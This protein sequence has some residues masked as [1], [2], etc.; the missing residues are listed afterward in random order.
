MVL[1][2]CAGGDSDLETETPDSEATDSPVLGSDVDG[3]GFGEDDCDDTDAQRF[4]GAPERCNGLDDDCDGNLH[5]EEQGTSGGE[6]AC[7][8]CDAAGFWPEASDAPAV[9][10]VPY[11]HEATTG[12]DCSYSRA[13]E[14]LFTDLDFAD[15]GVRC[16]YTNT[17]FPIPSYPPEWSKVNTE[18]TWPQSEG[19]DADPAQCDLHHLFPADAEVNSLRGSLPFG[20]VVNTDW[21]EAGSLKG[22]DAQGTTVFEPRDAHKGNVAR[23]M[24]YFA[25]RYDYPVSTRQYALYE[26][27]HNSDPPDATETARNLEIQ[28][29]QGNANPFV[30]CPNLVAR[31]DAL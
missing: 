28:E 10:L 22:K 25:V 17:F 7:A 30:A 18:H 6:L 19:A 13:R 2:A 24:L 26:S 5:P 31:L 9:D 1:A 3:D 4:P 21:S 12:V 14:Y 16:V 27:W 29:Q 15:G 8:A 23:A 11:L 20:E